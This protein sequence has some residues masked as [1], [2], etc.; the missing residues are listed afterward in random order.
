MNNVTPFIP[1][2]VYHV[3]QRCSINMVIWMQFQRFFFLSPHL[4]YWTLWPL[5]DS[6]PHGSFATFS[7]SPS[8]TWRAKGLT[9]S[10]VSL[11]CFFRRKGSL[12]AT[13]CGGPAPSAEM[14]G[15]QGEKWQQWPEKLADV[16]G[17]VCQARGWGDGGES[18]E[19]QLCQSISIIFSLLPL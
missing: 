19:D 14:K 8:F 6:L 17:W 16:G 10:S 1:C 12:F 5:G 2:R 15:C 18:D 9:M 11:P 4:C 3:H 7:H 13:H